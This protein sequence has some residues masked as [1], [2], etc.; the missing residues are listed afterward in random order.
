MQV[1]ATAL[2]FLLFSWICTRIGTGLQVFTI[3]NNEDLI[4]MNVM[5][6]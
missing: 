4:K 1:G 2:L 3:E 5:E 6:D